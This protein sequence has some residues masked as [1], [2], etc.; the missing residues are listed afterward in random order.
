MSFTIFL[1]IL[2]LFFMTFF[3]YFILKIMKQLKLRIYIN[4]KLTIKISLV[5]FCTFR[6][7]SSYYIPCSA[8][9]ESRVGYKMATLETKRE[10]FKSSTAGAH[11][12][13][14]FALS[15]NVTDS[16]TFLLKIKLR[17]CAAPIRIS[18]SSSLACPI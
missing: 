1:N 15:A 8:T 11:I 5:L 13:C 16:L 7:N 3:T 10:S 2:K 14:H 4:Y 17:Q 18:F 6:P 12:Y 9:G